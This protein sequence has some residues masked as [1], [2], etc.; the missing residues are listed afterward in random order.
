M[1]IGIVTT[2][3]HP[4][5]LFMSWHKYHHD[6]GIT[7]FILYFVDPVDPLI[8]E[9]ERRPVLTVARNDRHAEGAPPR[10]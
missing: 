7:D 8:P 5:D 9:V 2:V 4:T 6:R 3:W 1:R 10:G